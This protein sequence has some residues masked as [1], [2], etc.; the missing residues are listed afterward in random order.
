[1]LYKIGSMRKKIL[2]VLGRAGPQQHFAYNTFPE[3]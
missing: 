2:Y 3:D 1:L